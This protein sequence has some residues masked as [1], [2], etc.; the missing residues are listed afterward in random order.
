MKI[1]LDVNNYNIDDKFDYGRTSEGLGRDRA[2]EV[3]WGGRVP[4]LLRKAARYLTAALPTPPHHHD[5]QQGVEVIT[6]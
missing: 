6:V 1:A 2:M 5:N 3:G 4:Y